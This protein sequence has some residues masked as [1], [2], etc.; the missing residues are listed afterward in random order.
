MSA[1]DELINELRQWC[2][3]SEMVAVIE[4]FDAYRDEVLR[5][6]ATKIREDRD[7]QGGPGQYS[8]GMSRAAFLI[9]PSGGL[10][11]GGFYRDEV[12]R[13]A[14]AKIRSAMDGDLPDFTWVIDAYTA[15]DLIDPDV[16][17]GS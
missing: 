3:A 11:R 15:A 1:R 14:A 10:V 12:L 9:D 2:S 5:E 8:V 17:A 13:K 7:R 4:Q 6:A 16:Q